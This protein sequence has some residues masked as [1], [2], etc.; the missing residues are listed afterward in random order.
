MLISSI[1][2]GKSL[3][4]SYSSVGYSDNII[5]NQLMA[6]LEIYINQ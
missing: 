6:S 4:V 5:L 3:V 1:L 2:Q